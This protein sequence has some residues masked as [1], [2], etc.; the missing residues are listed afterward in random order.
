LLLLLLLLLLAG[1]GLGQATVHRQPRDRPQG[2]EPGKRVEG[3]RPAAKLD[4]RRAEPERERRPAVRERHDRADRDRAPRRRDG[5]RQ[6]RVD[7]G[8]CD[9]L[10]HADAGA[11]GEQGRGAVGGGG[12]REQRADRPRGEACGE[13]GGAAILVAELA[14]QDLAAG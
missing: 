8:E 5:A 3:E 6:Q 10:R 2:G 9:A 13:D 11:R 14:A 4:E 12:G 1:K 7:G